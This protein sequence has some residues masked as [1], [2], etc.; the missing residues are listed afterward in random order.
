M[1][2]GFVQ[3]I[4]PFFAI[5]MGISI[6]LTAIKLKHR[7]KIEEMRLNAGAGRVDDGRLARQDSRIEVLEDR[8]QVLERI[9]TDKGYDVASKI[10]AL[11]HDHRIDD[12]LAD[13]RRVREGEQTNG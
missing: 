2:W 1:D 11:R 8:V 10:E 12:E 6:P 3:F 4:I 7:Q 9:I 5:A 13:L